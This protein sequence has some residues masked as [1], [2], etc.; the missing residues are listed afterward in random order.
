M[1]L[2]ALEMRRAWRFA[3]EALPLTAREVPPFEKWAPPHEIADA[4]RELVR[5]CAPVETATR[6][7]PQAEARPLTAKALHDTVRSFSARWPL[8]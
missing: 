2:N 4:Y 8:K 7:L 1:S 3:R 5:L 6:A